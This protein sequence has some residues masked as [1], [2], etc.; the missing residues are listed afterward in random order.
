MMY[1]YDAITR[2]REA[3]AASTRAGDEI[4]L[5]TASWFIPMGELTKLRYLKYATNLFKVKR[6][7]HYAAGAVDLATQLLINKGDIRKVNLVSTASSTLIGN[8]F[9]SSVPGAFVKLNIGTGLSV[10][11]ASNFDVYKNIVLSTAGNI[12]GE[13]LGLG[14]SKN[15]TLPGA[16]FIGET[17]SATGAAV[18][19]EMT[20]TNK[21]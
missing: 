11:S 3:V 1:R 9:L 12:G 10:E 5:E 16:P 2:N 13:K 7:I 8:P 15:S 14:L 20:N 21:K 17:F 4:F 6:G 18:I 19:D